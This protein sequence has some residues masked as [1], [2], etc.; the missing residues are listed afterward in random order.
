MNSVLAINGSP[1]KNGNTAL[2]LGIVLEELNKAGFNT[3]LVNIGDDVLIGCQACYTCR[4]TRDNTCKYDNDPFNKVYRKCL[5]ADIILLGSPV[6]VGGMTSSLKA[7]IERACIVSRANGQP[8]KRKIGASIVAVRRNGA[9]ETFNSI[10]NFFT[11]SEMIVVGSSYWNQGIGKDKGDVLN[12]E[13]GIKTMKTLAE[14][15]IWTAG[16]LGSRDMA[17][18]SGKQGKPKKLKKK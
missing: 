13:E 15:I 11:I 8:F 7:F 12:D 4:K 16:R 6:Y 9:L 3:E 17:G 18:S 2:L 10:N 14:N 1:R 5:G